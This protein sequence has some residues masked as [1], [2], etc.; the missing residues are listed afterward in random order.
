MAFEPKNVSSPL[1]PGILLICQIRKKMDTAIRIKA[2]MLKI[3]PPRDTVTFGVIEE[4]SSDFGIVAQSNVA[5]YSTANRTA[6]SLIYFNG[7]SIS[8]PPISEERR[9]ARVI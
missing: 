2:T 3:N 4:L 7:R 6:L 5:C 1:R 8:A 9:I